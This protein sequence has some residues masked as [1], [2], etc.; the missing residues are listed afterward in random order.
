MSNRC[1]EPHGQRFFIEDV[2]PAVDAGRF[3][4][5]RIA[6]ERVNVWADILRDGHDVVAA[7]LRWRREDEDE[8]SS[9]PMALHSN[10]RYFG[11]FVPETPGRYYYAVEAW[12]DV[13]STWRRDAAAVVETG[14]DSR[15]LVHDGLSLLRDALPRGPKRTRMVEQ[16]VAGA[17]GDT[18]IAILLD[19][20]LS[21]AMQGAGP[22]PDL[23]LSTSFPLVAQRR[24]AR[25][26][27]WYELF[28][29]SQSPDAARHGTFRDVIGKVPQI[30]ALG[31]DVLY[32][33]PIHPVGRSH[34]KGR[35]NA[36]TAGPDDPGSV[37]AIGGAAGGHDAVHP[38]LGTL[39]DFRALVAA[40]ESH[41]MEI[42]LDFAVQC[43]PD[44]PWIKEHPQ[45]FK[46][47]ADGTVRYAENPPKKYE[48]IVN[49]D[50]LCAD[51]DA[52]WAALRDVILF[53]ITQGIRI[54]RVDNPH[55]KAFP[56][57]EWLIREV[58]GQHRD[59]VFLSE[60]FTR[61]KIMK[62]LA[63]LGF[64]QSYTYFTWRT[65]KAELSEYLSELTRYPEREYY[66]PNFF[67]NTPDILPYHLQGGERWMF[68]S[69][70]A[71]AATLSSSY[72]I[73]SG[74]ELL[75]HTPLPG[76]EEYTNSEKYELKHRDWDSPGNIKD[77]IKRLNEF[78]RANPALLQT[79]DLRFIP[80][81]NDSVLGFVKQSVEADNVVAAAIALKSGRHDIW[82]HFGDLGIGPANESKP[83]R[84]IVNLVTG[85][86]HYM[87]WGGMRVR[88]DTDSDPAVLFRCES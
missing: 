56:F 57:W 50:L 40:C 71:L 9:V 86:R 27:A 26:G 88:I 2:Y 16:V 32:F 48:D 12:T 47:R 87:E 45:W 23:T 82:L 8:W 42:A 44:H 69:R 75:E 28:P 14:G 7:S 61:P 41:G 31:F 74:F 20:T 6:G 37:Y 39:E 78:R 3:A 85:E 70:V 22:Q 54:F 65:D 53:W 49:P 51:R 77:Y 46:W 4:V 81:N 76:R 60:A 21:H 43:S 30:A 64:S 1:P 25:E 38:E 18:D 52:L 66:Q 72:G 19:P 29:R 17:N 5:K 13:F 35:N 73:Y 79:K 11:S 15:S 24:R 83:V 34:R 80:T 10:D 55:T 67:V 36:L 63:K 59:V 68:Q 58:L 33:P 84:S 62:A